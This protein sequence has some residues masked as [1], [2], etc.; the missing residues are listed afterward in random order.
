MPSTSTKIGLYLEIGSKKTFAGALDW[1]GWCLSG[2]DEATAL[3]ALYEAGPR[4]AKILQ[5]SRLGFQAPKDLTA[6][7]VVERLKGNSTT[8]FGAPDVAPE[9]DAKP[10]AAAEL[11]RLEKILQAGWR[12]FDAAAEAATGLALSKGPRGGGRELEGIVAH[13]LGAEAS[14][15]SQLGGQFKAEAKADAASEKRRLRAAI[16]ETLAAAV[17]GEI[18]ARGPRGGLRWSPRYFVRRAAWHVID[19]IWEIE[20]R[21]RGE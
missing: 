19:H 5:G 18:P 6:F 9:T 3:Q 21:S 4:Y 17:R 11:R 20:N 15:L 1:P 12:A 13:V 7:K 14:Y 2:R 16:L 10:V 8:D